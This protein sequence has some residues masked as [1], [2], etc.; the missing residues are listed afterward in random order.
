M[1]LLK[2]MAHLTSKFRSLNNGNEGVVYLHGPFF[3]HAM[4]YFKTQFPANRSPVHSSFRMTKYFSALAMLVSLISCEPAKK[5]F[6]YLSGYREPKLESLASIANYYA[7]NC[8]GEKMFLY[9]KD[10]ASFRR[11]LAY[12]TPYIA[13]YNKNKKTVLS[14]DKMSC[15]NIAKSEVPSLDKN[16]NYPVDSNIQA[17]TLEELLSMTNH[18]RKTDTEKHDFYVFFTWAKY[19]DSQ[20]KSFLNMHNN[21]SS[22]KFYAVNVDFLD[23]TLGKDFSVD[24]KVSN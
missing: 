9:P 18:N 24:V 23:A 4:R 6:M 10:S 12:G 17:T 3:Y 7:E 16:Q 8:K 22:V 2:P 5:G 15:V 11:L 20:S 1:A 13:I 21:K 14:S 19:M